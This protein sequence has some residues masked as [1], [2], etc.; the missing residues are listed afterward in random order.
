M[1]KKLDVV[2]HV[3]SNQTSD[4]TRL[5]IAV[6]R[7]AENSVSNVIAI[8]IKDDGNIKSINTRDPSL[9]DVFV[10]VTSK[11]AVDKTNINIIDE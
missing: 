6:D 4:G 3:T 5:T 1:S 9:E 7:F 8:V 10:D 2:Y 11:K